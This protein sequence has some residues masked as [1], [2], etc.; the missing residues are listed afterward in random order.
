VSRHVLFVCTGNT[1]RSPLAEAMARALAAARGL[2]IIVSSAG[3]SAPQGAPASDASILVGLERKLDLSTH[4]A[5]VLSRELVEDASLILGMAAHHVAAARALGGEG[6]VFLL[7][8]YAA[9][10]ATG[11]AILDPF[12]Q[13]LEAYR[14]MADD[15][16]VEMPRVIGRLADE[17]VASRRG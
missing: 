10:A 16:D 17:Q 11:R 3:T 15:L 8:D 9:N 7:T 13:A 12:G 1:C 14:R 4:R 5:R 2:D 6:R